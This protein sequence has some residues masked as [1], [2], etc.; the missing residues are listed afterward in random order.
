MRRKGEETIII[1]DEGRELI[2]LRVAF[3]KAWNIRRPSDDELL[4]LRNQTSIRRRP[5]D[6]RTSDV[7][8]TT[9]PLTLR[10][11]TSIRR[12]PMDFRSD[13]EGTRS[14]C[15]SYHM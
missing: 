4:T 2:K 13:D 7:H 3:W 10:Y 12:C 5:L 8:Q 6:S 9:S 14:K 15:H 1:N 11:Q